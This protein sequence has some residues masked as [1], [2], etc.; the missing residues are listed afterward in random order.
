MNNALFYIIDP[1]AKSMPAEGPVKR[2]LT[3]ELLTEREMK[4]CYALLEEDVMPEVTLLINF[5][6]ESNRL[7]RIAGDE[8][9]VIIIAK[10]NE[11]SNTK[12]TSDDLFKIKRYKIDAVKESTA[13]HPVVTYDV[14]TCPACK[15]SFKNIEPKYLVPPCPNNCGVDTSRWKKEEGRMIDVTNGFF[16]MNDPMRGKQSVE[17]Y[18]DDVNL[19]ANH[20]YMKLQAASAGL[21]SVI[22]DAIPVPGYNRE[23]SSYKFILWITRVSIKINKV[24][25]DHPVNE[26]TF[27]IDSKPTNEKETV[28]SVFMRNLPFMKAYL[29]F[30]RYKIQTAFPDMIIR[31][32]DGTKKI[33]EFEYESRNFDKHGH[34]PEI[35]DYIICWVDNR[36]KD[37]GIRVIVLRKLVGKR[38]C[39]S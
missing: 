34:D 26:I 23:G 37:D 21:G 14:L 35:T 6:R 1:Y 17:Y 8:K 33:I 38:L 32:Y 39:I 10:P 15:K 9:P 2:L 30:D 5:L 31:C 3:P 27:K 22:V 4:T 20:N 16:E 25:K 7:L 29:G 18:M 11:E 24:K 36:T 28:Q 13:I 12:V 19:D